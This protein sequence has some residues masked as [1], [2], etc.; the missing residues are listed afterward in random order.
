M[1][2]LLALTLVAH[3]ETPLIHEGDASEAVARVV[4]A[5]PVAAWDLDPVRPA[6]LWSADGAGLVGV[7]STCGGTSATNA[8]LRAA[9]DRAQL[10]MQRLDWAGAST[11][12]DAALGM[13]GCLSEEADAERAARVYLMRGVLSVESGEPKRAREAFERAHRF[14]LGEDGQPRLTWDD[15]LASPDKGERVLEEAGNDL[16][17][18][19]PGRLFVAPGVDRGRVSLRVDGRTV[20][21]PDAGELPLAS[22]YHLVQVVTAGGGGRQ[23]RTVE[24]ELAADTPAVLADPRGLAALP[25]GDHAGGPGLAALLGALGADQ[26]YV[27]A[28]TRVWKLDGEWELLPSVDPAAAARQQRHASALQGAGWSALGLGVVGAA[29]G[30]ARVGG[31]MEAPAWETTVDAQDWRQAQARSWTGVG[32]G[33]LVV[34]ATG[35]TLVGMGKAAAKR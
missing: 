23:V 21:L 9:T 15:R 24:I 17:A 31:F 8:D 20:P 25:L 11:D 32:V 4:A 26:A 33:G 30:F 19:A 28:D 5:D 27:Q 10:R 14:R 18:A 2:S 1:L 29:V 12:L 7:P 16:L 35:G 22:G 34:A 6:A 3:A 13:L